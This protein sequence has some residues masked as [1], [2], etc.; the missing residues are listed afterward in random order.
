MTEHEAESTMV[1]DPR[2]LVHTLTEALGP[3][4]VAALAGAKNSHTAESWASEN[5]PQP[6]PWAA[7]RIRFAAEQWRRISS[8]EDPD[9]A[10]AW[11]VGAN[12]WLQDDTPVNAIREGRFTDISHAIQALVDDSFSG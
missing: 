9:T 11:F 12:P 7:E 4:L 2:E 6:W 10:R 5:G 8:I 3:T 1:S